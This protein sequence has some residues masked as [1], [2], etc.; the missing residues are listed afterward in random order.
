[1]PPRGVGVR[2]SPLYV[3]RVAVVVHA[4]PQL[5]GTGW[6]GVKHWPHGVLRGPSCEGAATVG[7]FLDRLDYVDERELVEKI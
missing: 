7:E 5:G 3:P 2:L 1:M 6:T 4:A